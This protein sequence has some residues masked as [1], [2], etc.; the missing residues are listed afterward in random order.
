[1]SIVIEDEICIE[2][3]AHDPTVILDSL[4]NDETATSEDHI[5]SST[6]EGDFPDITS[7]I[8]VVENNNDDD[9]DDDDV[10]SDSG[11]EDGGDGMHFLLMFLFISPKFF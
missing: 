10:S 6:K 11:D 2:T 9:D 8:V 5:I 4:P 3:R 1:M 7:T